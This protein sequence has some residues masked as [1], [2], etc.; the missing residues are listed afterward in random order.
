M[1][2]GFCMENE[3][4]NMSMYSTIIDKSCANRVEIMV[5][6]LYNITINMAILFKRG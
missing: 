3:G 4:D 1:W 2:W 6:I 5:N